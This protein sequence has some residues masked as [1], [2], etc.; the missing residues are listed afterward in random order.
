MPATNGRAHEK[1][2]ALATDGLI[3]DLEDAVAPAQKAAGREQIAASLVA[4]SYAGKRLFLRINH[5]DDAAATEDL[6]LFV[7]QQA[8]LDGV[9]LPKAETPEAI[10]R[11]GNWLDSQQVPAHKRILAMVE[12]PKAVLS[13]PAIA[14]AHPRM[15]ALIA[16]TN[17]LAA[18]LQ[19]YADDSRAGLLYSLSQIVLTARAFDLLAYD[20][21]YNRLDDELGF[22]GECAQG[23]V[24]GFDGKTLIHPSQ[25]NIANTL[26]SPSDEE[27]VAAQQIVQSAAAQGGVTTAQ[28]AMVEELHVHNAHR[29]LALHAAAQKTSLE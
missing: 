9:V 3:F 28:G 23:R 18:A 17:D 1:A 21:V 2:A 19:L 26:F 8:R 22:A 6:A 7:Q 29:I 25:I 27:V 10:A 5:P 4:H 24:L 11:I 12:T 16:G 20:G 14:Q 13:L 15:A